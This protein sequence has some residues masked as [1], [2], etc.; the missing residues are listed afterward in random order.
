VRCEGQEV[1]LTLVPGPPAVQR[2]FQITGTDKH[3]TFEQA[4]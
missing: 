1:P 4:P 3:F 2:L